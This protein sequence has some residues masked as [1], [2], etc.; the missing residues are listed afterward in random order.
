MEKGCLVLGREF[1]KVGLACCR[2]VTEE[3]D[4]LGRLMVLKR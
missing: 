4:F 3:N 1:R 2:Q